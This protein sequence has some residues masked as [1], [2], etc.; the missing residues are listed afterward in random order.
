MLLRLRWDDADAGARAR[1]SEIVGRIW[2]GL[3]GVDLAEAAPIPSAL[4]LGAGGGTARR[5]PPG[6]PA[7]RLAAGPGAAAAPEG[8]AGEAAAAPGRRAEEARGPPQEPAGHPRGAEAARAAMDP[9]LQAALD[10]LEHGLRERLRAFAE[11]AS[12]GQRVK[13]PLEL[14]AVQRKAV[15]LW[16]EA[17]GLGHRSFGY[18]GRRRLHLTAPG[19]AEAGG[20]SGAAGA[21][22]EEFDWDAWQEDASASGQSDEDGA[23]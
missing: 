20:D 5:E 11:R 8:K 12:P 9:G 7:P 22:A 6:P 23:R 13:L 4:W 1:L 21:A 2:D 15:H 16:A 19:S 14:R 18:R 17:H 10:G 3:Q